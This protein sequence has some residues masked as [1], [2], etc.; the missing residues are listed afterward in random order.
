MEHFGKISYYNKLS[1]L[2]FS[3]LASAVDSPS[4]VDA[5]ASA[6]DGV[7]DVVF[8]VVA[9]ETFLNGAA[10]STL[11]ITKTKKAVKKRKYKKKIQN[12]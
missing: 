11:T 5:A 6:D 10:A 2:T 3:S 9:I 8:D 1:L 12:I 7:V 4:A